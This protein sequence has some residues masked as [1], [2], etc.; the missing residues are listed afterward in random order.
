M[1]GLPARTQVW[2]SHGDTITRVP[3]NYELIAS[4][5]GRARR[6]LP[7]RGRA[8]VGHP[9]PPRSVPFDRRHAAAAKTSSWTSAAAS[10][11]WTLG[12]FRGG[13]RARTAREAGRRQG[14][15]G[16]FRA[17]WIRRWRP[18]C[19]TRPSART[20]TASSSTRACCARTSSRSVL[21]SYKHMGLNVKG[22]NACGQ[23][24][25]AIWRA[26]RTPSG[27]ARSSAATSSRCSTK[28]PFRSRTSSGWR[29]GRS[30]PM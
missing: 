11:T 18:C 1:R 25:R 2:M 16:D 17:A 20:S 7:R 13:Y 19:C 4:T 5:G 15:A 23:V 12:G 22:V 30:I 29:R 28:R 24:P 3:D 10:R 26:L 21:E 9:V 8:D 6:R 14:R 27:S